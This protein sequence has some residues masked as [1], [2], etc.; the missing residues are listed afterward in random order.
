[1]Y[2][3]IYR[4]LRYSIVKF[5]VITHVIQYYTHK[6][7]YHHISYMSSYITYVY[8]YIYI[9]HI[10]RWEADEFSEVGRAVD[11][12]RGLLRRA[13]GGLRSGGGHPLQRLLLCVVAET[14]MGG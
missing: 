6:L 2:I 5:H 3:Y 9:S 4:I 12:Q 8:I 7:S 1:M 13:S 11:E 10:N 14:A